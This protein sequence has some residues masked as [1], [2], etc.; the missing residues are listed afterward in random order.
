MEL[1]DPAQDVGYGPAQSCQIGFVW[2]K[3]SHL[4]GGF[5]LHRHTVY[6]HL[7]YSLEQKILDTAPVRIGA[8]FEHGFPMCTLQLQVPA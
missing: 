2:V 3:Q 4:F 8:T 6:K 7:L 5:M 1:H